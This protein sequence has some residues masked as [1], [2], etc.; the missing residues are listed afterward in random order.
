MFLGL[1][2]P[3][4]SYFDIL[5]YTFT[6]SAASIALAIVTA[7]TVPLL[8]LIPLQI[9]RISYA[10]KDIPWVGQ[11][12][13]TWWSKL[14][15][16][17][18]ALKFERRNLEEGWEKVCRLTSQFSISSPTALITNHHSTVAKANLSSDL[19]STGLPSSCHLTTPNGSLNSPRAS[20]QRPKCKMKFWDSNGLLPD[21][22]MHSF[23]ISR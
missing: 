5:H 11:E 9:H 16:T 20:S 17:L 18:L 23:T 6:R 13:N 7:V 14:K 22:V 10:P 21:R 15:S 3:D 4:T 1:L 8:F 12:S 2:P 19:R